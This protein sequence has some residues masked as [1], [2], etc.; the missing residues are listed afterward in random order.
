MGFNPKSM[1][2]MLRERFLSVEESLKL[3]NLQNL[4]LVSTFV[5]IPFTLVRRCKKCYMEII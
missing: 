4:V 2:P 1:E 3:L 5:C